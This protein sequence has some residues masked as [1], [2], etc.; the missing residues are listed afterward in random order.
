MLTYFVSAHVL[1]SR[2]HG[3]HGPAFGQPATAGPNPRAAFGLTMTLVWIYIEMLR[4]AAIFA[5]GD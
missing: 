4:I 1:V 5:S 2:S 3:V